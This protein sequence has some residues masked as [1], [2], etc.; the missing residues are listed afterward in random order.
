MNRTTSPGPGVAAAA[1]PG[2]DGRVPAA[3]LVGRTGTVSDRL[4]HRE[5]TGLQPGVNVTIIGEPGE[6]PRTLM[7]LPSQCSVGLMCPRVIL[8]RHHD[9]VTCRPGISALC[10]D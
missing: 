9:V 3:R 10:T 2:P 5:V 1:T 4:S 7:R 8:P 6:G